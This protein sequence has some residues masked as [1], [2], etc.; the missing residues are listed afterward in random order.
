VRDSDAVG[1]G[2]KEYQL[3]DQCVT[4]GEDTGFVLG[5]WEFAC[6]ASR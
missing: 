4:G 3:R 5:C 2:R 6:S 1:A